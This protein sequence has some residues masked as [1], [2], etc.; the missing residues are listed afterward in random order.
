MDLPDVFDDWSWSQQSISSLENIVAYHLEAPAE[1]VWEDV[2]DEYPGCLGNNTSVWLCI[3]DGLELTLYQN[4]DGQWVLA[5]VPVKQE[6]SSITGPMMPFHFVENDN[7]QVWGYFSLL[8]MGASKAA[9]QLEHAQ[10]VKATESIETENDVWTLDNDMGR[11]TFSQQG[12]SVIIT[13]KVSKGG[14]PS[15]TLGKSDNTNESELPPLFNEWSW[16][17]KPISSLNDYVVGYHLEDPYEPDWDRIDFQYP[18]CPGG[19]TMVWICG[20]GK[21]DW[22]FYE[23]KDGQWILTKLE[24]GA[25]EGILE[26]QPIKLYYDDSAE[27]EV[28][29]YIVWGEMEHTKDM[30]LFFHN[31]DIQSFESVETNND[32]WHF[33]G[34]LGRLTFSQ[35]GKSIVIVHTIPKTPN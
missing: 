7:E 13:H 22:R 8:N 4:G 23:G 34:D 16:S 15:S 20:I 6:E 24:S 33:K 10:S 31:Q 1:P 11:V 12:E 21:A 26:T 32:I 18:L 28:W 3:A 19:K 30:L 27:A 35:E 5:S 25:P 14:A 9:M 2:H 17:I 29:A